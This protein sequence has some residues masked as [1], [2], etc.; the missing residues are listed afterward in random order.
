VGPREEK[1]A[2][3][4]IPWWTSLYVALKSKRRRTLPLV[5]SG[6]P[7]THEV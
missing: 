4:S 3:L 7:S 2:R 1:Y 5:T 6:L